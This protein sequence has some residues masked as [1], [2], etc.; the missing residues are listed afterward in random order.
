[1][2]FGIIFVTLPSIALIYY[3]GL[4][5]MNLY[6]N[7]VKYKT[8]VKRGTYLLKHA[9]VEPPN[10]L[11]FR[12]GNLSLEKEPTLKLVYLDFEEDEI[13]IECPASAIIKIAA[14]STKSYLDS[15]G[16]TQYIINKQITPK[17]LQLL[18]LNEIEDNLSKLES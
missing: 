8:N 4:S 5:A 11:D 15:K 6:K 13:V 7:H 18:I 10:E 1:M 3:G 17:N 9:I 16:N 14:I 12:S 2:L